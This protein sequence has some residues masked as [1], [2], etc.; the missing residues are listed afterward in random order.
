MKIMTGIMALSAAL[1]P[2]LSHAAENVAC[3]KAVTEAATKAHPQAKITSCKLEKENLY[4]V[5][6]KDGGKALA[7]NVTADGRITLTEEPVALEAVPPA[8]M[9]SFVERYPKAAPTM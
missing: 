4:E 9:K 5:I 6:V 2:L 7:L 3:P 8:V 1:F